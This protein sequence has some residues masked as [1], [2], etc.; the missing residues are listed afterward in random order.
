MAR[1]RRNRW[2]PCLLL[3]AC[4]APG[5][6]GWPAAGDDA[7]APGAA[8][9]P[10]REAP[11]YVPRGLSTRLFFD[12]GR[13]YAPLDLDEQELTL[14]LDVRGA[15]ARGAARLR[16]HQHVP[17]RPVFLLGA[18]LTDLTLD[19]RPAPFRAHLQD[20]DRQN[21]YY[22][23]EVELAAEEPH[24]LTAE[25]TLP[26]GQVR[27]DS[28]GVGLL[29]DMSD[30]APV[31]YF[32]PW[33]PTGFEDDQ[34]PLSLRILLAGATA[35]H[36]LYSNGDG[37]ARGEGEWRLRFP[38]WFTTSSFFVHLTDQ[39]FEAR[40]GSYG[41]LEREIPLLTYSPSGAAADAALAALPA[42]LRELEAD[43]GPYA[44]GRFV[45]LVTGADG[46]GME[47]AGATITSLRALGHELTH[48]WFARGVMP[49]D[50][51]S[52]WIDEGVATWRDQG[53]PRSA[54]LLG[55]APT[56]LGDHS[57]FLRPMPYVVHRDAARLMSEWDLLLAPRGGLRPL[58][59]GLFQR[60]ERRVITGAELRAYL[61][62]ET[63]EDL[64]PYYERYVSGAAPRWPLAPTSAH[65]LP[66]DPA[67]LR[68][69]R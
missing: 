14:S 50:G 10:L 30:L 40:R 59:R 20:P 37:G 1:A 16:F 55:A 19:G 47:H 65:P 53:Y 29:T 32:E 28:G 68:A 56:N 2:L 60:Y 13:A 24:E 18:A 25:F 34:F 35:P 8:A 54:A 22:A 51:R 41:G 52:G 26:A 64:G 49:A 67:A 31:R 62:G 61:E 27:F 6:P 7:P 3:A 44:H 58:L 66:P 17:S 33:A 39:P 63:G 38:P 57:P 12:G 15:T 48:S 42:L 43:Y 4:G 23:V 21:E 9:R 5:S 69:L 36:A 11:G 45:A 46:G